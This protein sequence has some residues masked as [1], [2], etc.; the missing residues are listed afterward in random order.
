MN[1]LFGVKLF[2][3]AGAIHFNFSLVSKNKEVVGENNSFARML[4]Y[5]LT[6]ALLAEGVS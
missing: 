1:F 5:S 6:P 3:T 2:N 4:W